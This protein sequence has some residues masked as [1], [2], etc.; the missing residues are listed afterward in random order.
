MTSNGLRDSFK[1]MKNIIEAF[2]IGLFPNIEVLGEPQLGK[3]NLYPNTSK[4][5]QRPDDVKRRMDTRH[6]VILIIVYLI[7]P[8]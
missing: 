8:K 3:R 5:Y 4:R 6:I 1:V 2:E 7:Y